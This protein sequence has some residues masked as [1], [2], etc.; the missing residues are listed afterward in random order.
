MFK[1]TDEF[2]TAHEII[3]YYDTPEE[4]AEGERRFFE[5]SEYEVIDTIADFMASGKYTGA[6]EVFLGIDIERR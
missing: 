5:P 2:A 6:L 1:V 3:R 4:F